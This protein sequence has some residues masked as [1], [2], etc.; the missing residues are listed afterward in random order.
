VVGELLWPD[1]DP[2]SVAGGLRQV[3]YASRRA[4][5]AAHS[6]GVDVLT[7]CDG[8]VA[9]VGDVQ[10]DVD[11]FERASEEALAE[12]T[13]ARCRRALELYRGA[14]LPEDLYEDWTMAKRELLRERYLR[15]LLKSA[16]LHDVAG[17]QP[18]TI[19]A[20]QRVIVEDPLYEPAHRW[21]MSCFLGSGRDHQACAQYRLLRHLLESQLGAGPDLKTRLLYR[22]ILAAPLD[23][24]NRITRAASSP[25]PPV[26]Y[27]LGTTRS[28]W[29]APTSHATATTMPWNSRRCTQRET[30]DHLNREATTA[31]VEMCR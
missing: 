30:T 13:L 26:R 7:G 9:L 11:Q 18:A 21:L 17:D 1:G 12:P 2:D 31:T 25:R 20:L 23:P 14:L 29:K 16:E 19:D 4:L 5:R 10:T 22:E 27:S 24:A 28:R 3:I 15:L 8:V 6:D